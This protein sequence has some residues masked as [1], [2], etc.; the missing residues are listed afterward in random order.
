MT[1]E[2]YKEALDAIYRKYVRVWRAIHHPEGLSRLYYKIERLASTSR[3]ALVVA[4]RTEN[5]E[6]YAPL[7]EAI[8]Y[9]YLNLGMEDSGVL[10]ALDAHTRLIFSGLRRSVIPDADLDYLRLAGI[11][12]AEAEV[13]LLIRYARDEL[14]KSEQVPSKIVAEAE[15]Q[16]ECVAKE[17]KATSKNQNSEN[18][19]KPAK[20]FTGISKILAGGITAAGNLL[21]GVGILP[22]PGPA[23]GHAVIGS[24]ALAI[25]AIGQ[26]IGNIRGE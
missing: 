12:E 11:V 15:K 2:E 16:L 19:K 25:A 10:D 21:L 6:L 23:T 17:L 4:E 1:D 5:V 13:V 14:S 9:S 8:M 7:G 3:F 20:L 22:G 18:V 24:C 26:G